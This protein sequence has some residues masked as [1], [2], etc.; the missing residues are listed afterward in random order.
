MCAYNEYFISSTKIN[1]LFSYLAFRVRSLA[2]VIVS[3]VAL[4]MILLT[5]HFRLNQV[6]LTRQL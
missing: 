1:E 3:E 2:S 6:N 5:P 4:G